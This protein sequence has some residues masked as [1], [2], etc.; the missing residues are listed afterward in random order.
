M[1]RR[2]N[3]ELKNV[4]TYGVP[5]DDLL[6]IDCLDYEVDWVRQIPGFRYKRGRGATLPLSWATWCSAQAVLGDS[7][8]P[9]E[10]FTQWATGEYRSRVGT[11]LAMR[12]MLSIE[13]D[14][15]IDGLRP[16]QK[17][18]AAWMALN[19][20]ALLGNEAGSGKTLSTIAT[21]DRLRR[22]GH[23][24]FPALIISPRS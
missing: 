12:D 6:D 19:E 18:D 3:V 7:F 5:Q 20:R 17:V 1:A 2:I 21:L 23:D 11:S 14:D 24:V 22:F 10:N 9:D 4:T 15:F 13:G 8:A 16:Y